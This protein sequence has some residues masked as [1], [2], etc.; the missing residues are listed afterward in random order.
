MVGIQR[1]GI[2]QSGI[3]VARAPFRTRHGIHAEVYEV[4]ILQLHEVELYLRRYDGDK[5]VDFLALLVVA[6]V[7][8][9]AALVELVP[10]LVGLFGMFVIVVIFAS[11]EEAQAANTYLSLLLRNRVARFISPYLFIGAACTAA[12]ASAASGQSIYSVLPSSHIEAYSG[13]KGIRART[14]REYFSAVS[15]TPPLPKI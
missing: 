2:E 14:G 6:V 8:V 10:L 1:R 4:V 12:S 5:T 3:F 7:V 11:R 9:A 15:S 13:R